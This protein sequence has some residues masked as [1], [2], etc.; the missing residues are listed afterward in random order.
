MEAWKKHA[1]E[2]ATARKNVQLGA[3]AAEFARTG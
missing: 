3:A 1:S 2:Q